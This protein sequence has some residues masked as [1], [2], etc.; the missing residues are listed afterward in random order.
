[1]NRLNSLVLRVL[2]TSMLAAFVSGCEDPKQPAAATVVPGSQPPV[3]QKPAAIQETYA[4][5]EDAVV[6]LID[7]CRKAD[8]DLLIPIFGPQFANLS[9]DPK[10]R[11][12]GDLQRIA[13]AYDRVHSLVKEDDGSVTLLVGE[14]GWDFPAPIVQVGGRWQFDT[15]EGIKEM[16]ARRIEQNEADA[17]LTLQEL[18]ELQR[19]FFA[20]SEARGERPPGYATRLRSTPG[21]RDGLYWDDA[22]GLPHSPL[23]PMVEKAELAR[24]RNLD[25]EGQQAYRG[26]MFRVLT[27]QGK[28]APGGARSY[29]DDQGRMPSEFALLAWPAKYGETGTMTFQIFSDATVYQKDLGKATAEEAKAMV[30]FDPA[31]WEKVNP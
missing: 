24:D 11:T 20:M 23:G 16:R 15:E 26:Y 27:G 14:N 18:V 31:G 13:A 25:P 12:Q 3:A 2:C 29:T 7:T 10:D 17:I 28:G 5:P 30:V 22:L 8:F 9:V 6:A 1:M 19:E 4:T 21:K